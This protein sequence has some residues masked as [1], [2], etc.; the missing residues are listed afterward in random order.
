MATNILKEIDDFLEHSGMAESTFGKKTLNDG[1][2][3]D[4]LRKGGDVVSRNLD[5][6]R[7]FIAA[8]SQDK[9]A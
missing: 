4:R 7:E 5:K 3:V 1:K 8:N 6:I 9:A 2:L